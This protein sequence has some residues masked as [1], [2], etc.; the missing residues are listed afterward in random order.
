M[1]CNTAGRLACSLAAAQARAAAV[2]V[3]NIW[4][5]LC[6][7]LPM[8]NETK[9]C[10]RDSKFA[11]VYM[12]RDFRGAKFRTAERNFGAQIKES[13]LKVHDE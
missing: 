2:A 3:V 11:Q 9:T 8:A 10:A 6:R 13:M 4:H 12:G 7:S 1:L 5:L